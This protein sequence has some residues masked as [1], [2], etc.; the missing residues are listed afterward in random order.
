[1]KPKRRFEIKDV[2]W[3]DVVRLESAFGDIIGNF[4]CSA[5]FSTPCSELDSELA[6]LE[7]RF[8]FSDYHEENKQLRDDLVQLRNDNLV[9]QSLYGFTFD[10]V[11]ADRI[12]RSPIKQ[13]MGLSKQDFDGW[14]VSRMFFPEGTL[15]TDELSLDDLLKASKTL[16]GFSIRN[17]VDQGQKVYQI[18]LHYNQLGQN[19]YWSKVKKKSSGKKWHDVWSEILVCLER[20]YKWIDA[21]VGRRGK[22]PNSVSKRFS[23]IGSLSEEV[24][25]VFGR[26]ND[27]SFNFFAGLESRYTYP[28]SWFETQD[29]GLTPRWFSINTITRSLLDLH[30]HRKI[31]LCSPIFSR[32][33]VSV[34]W[35]SEPGSQAG[36]GRQFWLSRDGSSIS[37]EVEEIGEMGGIEDVVKMFKI[38]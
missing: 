7:P 35:G 15:N 31:L 22:V 3:S 28:E 17:R 23:E 26:C 6:V 5:R 38:D 37:I 12:I 36:E 2:S 1:M 25:E 13:A 10:S 16:S 14:F 32:V 8:E 27:S 29:E 19:S 11:S 21:G 24:Q 20:D 34:P 33:D 4:N 18:F 30:R 9:Q